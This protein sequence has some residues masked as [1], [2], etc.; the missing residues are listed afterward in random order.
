MASMTRRSRKMICG[1]LQPSLGMDRDCLINGIDDKEVQQCSK[2][3]TIPTHLHFQQGIRWSRYCTCMYCKSGSSHSGLEQKVPDHGLPRA[4]AICRQK[5]WRG[6][7]IFFSDDK[8]SL[9]STVAQASLF[10]TVLCRTKTS[11]KN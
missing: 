9:S 4:G 3:G 11:R 2:L 7:A 6:S 8:C 5:K 10:V 1:F